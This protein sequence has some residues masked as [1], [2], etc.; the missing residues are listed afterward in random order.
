ML[1]SGA[2][3]AMVASVNR[4]RERWTLFFENQAGGAGRKAGPKAD[5]LS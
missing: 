2:T 1:K 4:M 5:R 3:V